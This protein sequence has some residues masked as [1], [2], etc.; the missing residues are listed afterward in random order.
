M[1]GGL[2]RWKRGSESRGIRN[3]IA[4]ALEGVC[5]AH[6]PI[7]GAKA[8]ERYADSGESGVTRFMVTDGEITSDRLTG[9]GLRVW[10][11][12]H[13]PVTG[14][15]RGKTL[16]RPES[17]L[18]LDGTLNHPKSFSIA[19]LLH[20]ELAIELEA[21]QDRV[22][23]RVLLLWQQELNA[24]RGHGGLIRESIARLEVVE[25][26]HRR[27]RALDPH[28][29]RH[30]WLN[31]K[32]QG[33]DGR[34]TNVDSRV[35][36]KVHT[37]VNAEGELAARTDPEWIDALARHGY[38]LDGEGEIA[39]LAGAVRPFSRRSAQIEANRSR[40][41]AEWSADHEGRVPSVEV[42]AQIDRRAWAA[43][44]PNKPASL[45][46]ESW[47]VAVREELAAIDPALLIPRA[48]AP[49]AMPSLDTLDIATLA[50]SAVVDADDRSRGS[51]GR[52]S[53]IDLRAGALRAMSR[54]G[55]VGTREA[56]DATIDEI[57]AG[58]HRLVLRLS[59]ESDVPP[60][61]KSLMAIETATS[62]IRLAGS[63][64]GLAT[65][66]RS[67]TPTEMHRSAAAT[68]DV[69]A[70]D[71]SQ[72]AAACA[73][74]GSAG[75][76]AVTGPAG[77]GK[78]AMLRA[79]STA[80]ARQRRRMLVVAP[81]RKAAMVAAREVGA[82]ATSLHS[83]LYDY[84]YRWSRAATGAAEWRRLHPGEIDSA[85]GVEYSGPST[86]RVRRGDRIVVDEA[87]MVDLHAANALAIVAL[88]T[89]AGVAMVG[90][91]RQAVPVGHAGAM[92]SVIRHADAAVELDTVHRFSDPQYAALTL[93]LRDVR[94][95]AEALALAGELRSRGHVQ[96]VDSAEAA[97]QVMVTGYLDAAAH[98]RRTVLV[99]GTNSEADAINAEIQQ[100][101]LDGGDLDPTAMAWG[102]EEQRLFV[103]DVVETRRN[104]SRAGVANRAQW[105]IAGIRADAIDLA[106]PTEAGEWRRIS[107]D[108][109]LD[110]V[111]LAYASTVHGVQGETVDTAIVGPD[112]DAAGL[113]V[114]LTRGR[115]HN[116]AVVIARTEPAIVEALAATM[117]RGTTEVTIQDSIDA[118]AAELRRSARHRATGRDVPM[119][120]SVGVG[121]SL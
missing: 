58:A 100:H 47:E 13:D 14:E 42:L 39:E 80:L 52:F 118:A 45:D 82:E 66:G 73:I 117:V 35:A 10:L 44:R 67:L 91:P 65:S 6:V 18:L 12:G 1:R 50:A 48:P 61:V 68:V 104:D 99:C 120:S 9:A 27:S 106:S 60:H 41:T 72:V 38:T 96:R 40:L 55:V 8:L 74:A 34:W 94:E 28:A 119:P 54:T 85:T 56:F 103:G 109:A 31:I 114:G 81:T 113:Y 11:S 23:D 98:G 95:K 63:L 26:V 90:D 83:L 78:T 77:T 2:E 112:V 110:H 36:M 3:A 108:Y 84:G 107:R 71:R 16:V 97:R 69:G 29:H 79:A 75:L 116:R 15:E 30:L 21:M 62:K 43:S 19:A 24:R 46:E 51:S 53:A 88:E 89:G 7:P 4:Y 121:P 25:L 20:P 87:G 86:Y 33:A 76:V 22:R 111:R 92:A 70:L 101:R 37:L 49:I 5:D 59:T 105:V 102:S 64:D 93:R 57:V 32:V 115:S 17:D